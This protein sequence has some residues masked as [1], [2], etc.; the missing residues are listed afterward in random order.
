MQTQNIDCDSLERESS[1]QKHVRGCCAIIRLRG[2]SWLST[3]QNRALFKQFRFFIMTCCMWEHAQVPSYILDGCRY[4]EQYLN[5]AELISS[6]LLWIV[7]EVCELRA[8][9]KD[10]ILTDNVQICQYARNI[11]NDLATWADAARKSPEPAWRYQVLKDT[12]LVSSNVWRNVWHRYN[13]F[14]ANMAYSTYRASRVIIMLLLRDSLE[15]VDAV[16]TFQER[17]RLTEAQS[18]LLDEI[19]AGIPWR[20]G[21]PSEHGVTGLSQARTPIIGCVSHRVSRESF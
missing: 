15:R 14:P 16:A 3:P 7:A 6:R 20:L 11:N 4:I 9:V 12:S 1:W 2:Q 17:K 21:H 19:C 13:D 18:S 10:H 8:K 5:E